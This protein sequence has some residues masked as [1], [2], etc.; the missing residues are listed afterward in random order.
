MNSK[1]RQQGRW[2]IKRVNQRDAFYG[3]CTETGFKRVRK[4]AARLSDGAECRGCRDLSR[5]A[6]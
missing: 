6:K 1:A 2:E 3:N 4:Y 5:Q